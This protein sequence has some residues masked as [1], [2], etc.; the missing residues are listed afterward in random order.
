MNNAKVIDLL[1]WMYSLIEYSDKYTKT[2]SSFW[3][4][5]RD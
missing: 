5:H 1:M 4:Y 2:S 3:Q